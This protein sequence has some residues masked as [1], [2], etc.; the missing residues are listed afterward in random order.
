MLVAEF[1]RRANTS[2]S[3]PAATGDIMNTFA[4]ALMVFHP[5]L[6][7]GLLKVNSMKNEATKK[8]VIP[9]N[10][11]AVLARRSRISL[12]KSAMSVVE[13]HRP[14]RNGVFASPYAMAAGPRKRPPATTN[15]T[16]LDPDAVPV[17]ATTMNAPNMPNATAIWDQPR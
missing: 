7:W 6:S 1:N 16:R 11:A 15:K 14:R 5:E 4:I 9:A 17:G 8:T 2:A 12:R 13:V 3:K 10:I